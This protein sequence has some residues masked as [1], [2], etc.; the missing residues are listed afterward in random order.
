MAD[1]GHSGIHGRYEI[2][3]ANAGSEGRQEMK[4]IASRPALAVAMAAALSMTATP[5]M[6]RG[7]GGWG[8]YHHHDGVDAGDIFAGLLAIGG[9]AAIAAAVSNSHKDRRQ[10]D[11]RYPQPDY[12]AP[13][14]RY[15]DDRDPRGYRDDG[16]RSSFD[17]DGAVDR[18]VDEVERGDRRVDE[19]DS[20]W[21]DGEGWRVEGR[22]FSCSIDGDGRIRGMTVGRQPA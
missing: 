18:C 9:I 5:A 10:R 13:P 17:I 3:A 19:V 6:A 7:W 8:H 16:G 11:Y 20:V 1:V 21:R 14:A 22:D 15:E 2:R 4:I 12:R